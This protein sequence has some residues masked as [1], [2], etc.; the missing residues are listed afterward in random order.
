MC[1][2]FGSR[3][4]RSC[5]ITNPGRSPACSRPTWGLKSINQTSP[6]CGTR[7]VGTNLL[8]FLGREIGRLVFQTVHRP[9]LK[10]GDL[11]LIV[12]PGDRIGLQSRK[13]G[14]DLRPE[15]LPPITL[16]RRFDHLP[17]RAMLFL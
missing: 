3:L 17:D 2:P 4:K 1:R 12:L 9:A 13:R 6:D 16:N 10:Q 15:A 5:E 11:I 8:Q 14:V 7:V